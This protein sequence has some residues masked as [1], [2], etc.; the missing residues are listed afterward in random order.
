MVL[1]PSN[2]PFHVCQPL[3][4]G[5]GLREISSRFGKIDTPWVCNT[6]T[7]KRETFLWRIRGCF[8]LKGRAQHWKWPPQTKRRDLWWAWRI[9]ICNC[10]SSKPAKATKSSLWI[11][12]TIKLKVFILNIFFHLSSHFKVRISYFHF[13]W[14]AEIRWKQTPKVLWGLFYCPVLQEMWLG[15]DDNAWL[16]RNVDKHV[17]RSV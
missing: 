7:R 4:Q 14:G 15:E 13:S 12:A 9:R 3:V 11:A 5:L 6:T 16:S 2:S 8:N 1:E 10:T 17:W